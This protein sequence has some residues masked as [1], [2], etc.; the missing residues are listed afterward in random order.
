MFTYVLINLPFIVAVC[1]LDVVIL[2]TRVITHKKTWTILL[3]LLMLT[4]L[5][6]QVLAGFVYGY[7]RNH[8]I[9]VHLG[10]IPIEDFG[11]TIAAVIGLGALITYGKNTKAS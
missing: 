1:V 9:G 3:I 5:F 8:I 4:A 11:Y 6:D 2:K 10:Y 7:S